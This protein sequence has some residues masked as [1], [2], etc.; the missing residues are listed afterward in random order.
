MD[1]PCARPAR[2]LQHGGVLPRW[3]WRGLGI[4]PQLHRRFPALS[5][6][7]QHQYLAWLVF[8]LSYGIRWL[9]RNSEVL[10]PANEA[11]LPFYVLQQPM[12]IGIAFYVVQ[13]HMAILPKWLILCTL[14]LA[15]ARALY[16]LLIRRV[17]AIRWLFGMKPRQRTPHQDSNGREQEGRQ[18]EALRWVA[19]QS[20]LSL[21]T[22]GKRTRQLPCMVSLMS[23]LS[24]DR[25][26]PA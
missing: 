14:A 13:W 8:I 18:A 16:E 10:G 26:A 12:I 1:R 3:P 9:N 21:C 22:P 25:A 4:L 15:M 5:T 7:V 24:R 23:V 11:V 2:L 17:N 20:S 6:G 19:R